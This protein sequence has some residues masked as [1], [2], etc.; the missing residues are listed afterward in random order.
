METFLFTSESINE[1]HPDK[2]CDQVSDAILDACREQDPESKVACETCTTTNMVMVFGEIT[3]NPSIGSAT[4]P[5]TWLKMS[6]N[7]GISRILNW[8]VLRSESSSRAVEEVV[9]S[10]SINQSII[11]NG[12][13]E[14]RIAGG[15]TG[16][17]GKICS[18]SWSHG[19][20]SDL[21]SSRLLFFQETLLLLLLQVDYG[22]TSLL[23]FQRP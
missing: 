21:L 12:V 18:A 23:Q 14:G 5:S 6:G 13:Y 7:R 9:D 20:C 11:I 4:L 15:E 19:G 2:L 8:V 3:T 16:S 17:P 22:S 10:E 1:G